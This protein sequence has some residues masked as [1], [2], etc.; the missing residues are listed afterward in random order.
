MLGDVLKNNLYKLRNTSK[1]NFW[2]VLRDIAYQEI[3]ELNSKVDSDQIIPV[4]Y[5]IIKQNIDQIPDYFAQT[6]KSNKQERFRVVIRNLFTSN[7]LHSSGL[8]RMKGI[9]AYKQIN[10]NKKGYRNV[11]YKE[12]VK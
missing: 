7:A 8:G 2:I 1:N 10:E 9:K 5:K 12:D 3:I 4:Y 11:F 6:L